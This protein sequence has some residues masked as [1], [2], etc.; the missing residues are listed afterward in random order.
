MK[1]LFAALLAGFA[2]LSLPAAAGAI[3]IKQ[4][5]TPLGIKA[6]LVEDKSTPVIALSFSFVGG[7]A[8]DPAGLSGAT[9][10]MAN[11]L[12]DGAGPL[13]AQAFRQRQEDAAA[14]IGFN[15]S[16][17]RVSGSLRVLSAN[18]DEG[19]ELLRLAMVEP[20]FDA[21]MVDQRRAQ[22]I[23]S[24]NQAAQRPASVAGR[25]LM[26]TLFADHP[27][28]ADPEGTREDLAKVTSDL[29]KKRAAAVLLRNGLTVAAVGD[30]SEAELARQIDTTGRA[31]DFITIDGGEG[32]TGAAPL[33]FSDHV[34]LP[35]KLGFSTIYRPFA[36]RSLQDRIVFIGSGKL[37]FP[38]QA[39]L[40]LGLGCDL[41]NVAREA[42]LAIGCIQ[43]Q[44][45]HTG[46]CP[47]G[48]ATQSAWLVG[49]LDPTDKAARLANYFITLRKDLYGLAHACGEHHP[50]FVSLD[51]ID[52]LDGLQRR[53][54]REVFNYQPTWGLP[55]PALRAA[56]EQC[57]ADALAARVAASGPAHAH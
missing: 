25:T 15:A 19:F 17:D 14:S 2:L 16:L 39:L 56:T 1:R 11:L 7:T 34:A 6:W 57:L 35:F 33:V 52:L 38:A 21:A 40:A 18:R 9:D 31:P 27:Y 41:I 12:T 42:M 43:A 47:T 50:A 46:H 28:A 55:G 24:L 48:V 10:L 26:A 22:T 54:A 4:V 29:L 32:G 36:E 44:Q 37:G 53:P 3:E 49:G 45:C 5:T 13:N 20:R 23:A 30:I 51:R 8:S